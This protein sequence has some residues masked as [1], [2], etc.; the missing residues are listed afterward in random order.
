MINF[1]HFTWFIINHYKIRMSGGT[2]L[3]DSSYDLVR[4]IPWSLTWGVKEWNRLPGRWFST[5]WDDSAQT[6]EDSVQT[7][8]IQYRL[9]L[10][11]KHGSTRMRE[12]CARANERAV[13]ANK[14]AIERMASSIR[15]SAPHCDGG[16]LLFQWTGHFIFEILIYVWLVCTFFF[17][18]FFLT[19]YGHF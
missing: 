11:H 6:W 13:L 7:E 9:R 10:F 3:T 4:R 8:M 2:L 18:F 19:V 17:S 14:W 16:P 5:D 12:R 15:P 1:V